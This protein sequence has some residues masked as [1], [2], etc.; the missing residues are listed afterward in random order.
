MK[1]KVLSRSNPAYVIGPYRE[2]ALRVKPGEVFCVE[3]EDAYGGIFQTPDDLVPSR[4]SRSGVGF[5]NPVTGPIAIEGA[6]PGDAVKVNITEVR[7]GDRGATR[8][9][10]NFGVLGDFAREAQVF[11]LRIRDKS[12]ILPDG[13]TVPLAPMIGTIGVSPVLEAIATS[14]PGRHGGNLDC[15]D[16]GPGCELILPVFVPGAFLYLGDVHATQGDGEFSGSAVE[17][18]AE[19]VL[20]VDV[21][22]PAPQSLTGPRVRRDGRITALASDKP[23]DEAVRACVSAMVDWLVADYGFDRLGAYLYLTNCGFGRV[24]QMVNPLYTAGCTLDERA[25]APAPAP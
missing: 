21:I 11:L 8:L 9:R 1:M 18:R 23:L 16:I 22:S 15:R 5:S 25:L 6:G 19:V 24:C 13:R 4:L 10:P 17:V 14:L 12:A 20:S 7:C 3:T 2:P